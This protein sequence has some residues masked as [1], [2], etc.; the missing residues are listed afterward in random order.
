MRTQ[1]IK[2]RFHRAGF[3]VVVACVAVAAPPASSAK[4][5]AACNNWLEWCTG[6]I[7][8]DVGMCLGFIMA[9]DEIHNLPEMPT[10]YCRAKGVTVGQQKLIVEKYLRENPD[11]LH[12]PFARL[13]LDALQKAFPCPPKKSN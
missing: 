10:I 8:A 12:L 7:P 13:A 3:L 11:K 2:T 4:D 6:D 1:R 9:V 5:L